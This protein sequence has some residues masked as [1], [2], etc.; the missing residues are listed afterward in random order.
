MNKKTEDGSIDALKASYLT[1]QEVHL[2]RMKEQL[3][4]LGDKSKKIGTTALIVGGVLLVGY[5]VGRKLLSKKEGKVPP[6]I[7]STHLM[8]QRPKSEP[9]IVTLIKEQMMLFVMAVI[10]EKLTAYIN[11]VENKK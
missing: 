1:E 6:G 5:I 9:A 4:M 8:I 11:A 2:A 3:S 10:K 7:P